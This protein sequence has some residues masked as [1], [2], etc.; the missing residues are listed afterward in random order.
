[1]AKKKPKGEPTWDPEASFDPAATLQ[2]LISSPP[3]KEVSDEFG[4]SA[5]AG[6]RIPFW[7]QRRFQ[8]IIEMPG[9]PYDLMSDVLRDALYLGGRILHM[10]YS[11]SADWDVE[12]KMAAAVDA[13]TAS[14]RIKAQVDELI[15]GLDEMFR[16]GDIDKAAD[17]LTDYVVAAI[18]LD[19]NW[20]KDKV[21]RMLEDS[22]VIRDLVQYCPSEVQKLL[23]QGARK[24][25]DNRRNKA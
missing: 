16:D 2:D 19:N 23:E 7:L 14:R 24:E 9:S 20:H 8:K 1:M 17:S 5:T 12:T 3:F 22:K 25:Q 6:S 18:D 15:A 10:R 13:T 11:M 4:H 21:F